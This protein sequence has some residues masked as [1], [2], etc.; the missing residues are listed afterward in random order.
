MDR[1]QF[2]VSSMATFAMCAFSK[3]RSA[4]VAEALRQS[5]AASGELPPELR[6]K[7][8]HDPFRPQFH[9]LPRANWMNDPCAPRFH[10]GEYHM[11]FQY[12][13][14][15]AV[16]GDMHW[17]H[18]TSP[19]LIHWKHQPLALS[20]TPD[21]YDAFGCFTGSVLPGADIPTILYTGV[22][23]SNPETIRG[24]GLREV[25][26]LAT[27][28]DPDLRVWTKLDKPVIE[29]PPTGLNVT[30]FRDPCPWK[31]G[32]IWY[33]GVG[34]GFNKVGGA[35]LLYRSHDGHNWEY[36]HPLAQGTW[37]GGTMSNPVDTG[38]M[39]ECPDFFPLG[40]KHVLLYSVERKVFWEVGVFDKSDL[41]FHSETKGMLDQGYYYAM[42]SMV[43]EKGRRILWGWVQESR[44]AN[45]CLAA[46]WAGSMAL[47]RVLTLGSDNR[48]C[49]DVPP[50]F[51]SLRQ[52]TQTVSNPQSVEKLKE[53]F[54]K[55]SIQNRAGEVVYEFKPRTEVCALELRTG[56]GGAPLLAVQYN[57]ASEKPTLTVG[58]KT[59]A[60]SPDGG[61][62]STVHL[63]IDGSVIEIFADSREALTWRNFAP[64]PGDIQVAW[65]GP[66]AALTSIS[67]SSVKPISD[68]RL[69]S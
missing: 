24:E 47:P 10:R 28:T 65:T 25:Q 1:R 42:K 3:R 32:D 62:I 23:K 64:S 12:N 30:G 52:Q 35:V 27:S 11:F 63:W 31:D 49:M 68:D 44:S 26:C 33:L 54:A 59:L 38:E 22:T 50:E 39:W 2:V 17:N 46:G 5:V 13:P 43:D 9:L 34:S 58:E 36:L 60:L 51:A 8:M 67:V 40:G 20:P 53:G 29:A 4:A 48:L 21:S 37:N 7:L 66:A 19:D 55:L 56:A 41:R 16:W 69:T 45:E 15:A 6:E 61:G 14:H 57:G 18:A